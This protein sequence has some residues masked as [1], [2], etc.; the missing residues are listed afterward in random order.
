MTQIAIEYQKL[1][2]LAALDT[3]QTV[4]VMFKRMIG[5]LATEELPSRCSSSSAKQAMVNIRK[6]VYD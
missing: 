2:P 3:L 5:V 4:F 6:H 1:G